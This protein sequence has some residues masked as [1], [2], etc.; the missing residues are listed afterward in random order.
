MENDKSRA[1]RKHN[2]K[3]Q[4]EITGTLRK[5]NHQISTQSK[6]KEKKKF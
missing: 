2:F 4:I 1:N 5:V 3:K 6:T